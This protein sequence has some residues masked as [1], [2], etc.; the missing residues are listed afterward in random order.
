MLRVLVPLVVLLGAFPVVAAPPAPAKPVVA[1]L[2]FDVP[3]KNEDLAAFRKGLAEM[4]IT[5]LVQGEQLSVVERSR[6]EEV[7]AELELSG[8]GKVDPATAQ[9]IGKLLGARYQVMGSIVPLGKLMSFEVKVVRV[10]TGQVL[11][12]TRERAT[13]DDVFEAEQKLAA[14]LQALVAEAEKLVPPPPPKG[15]TKLRYDTAVK[16]SKALD[17][18]DKKNKD[19]AVKLLNEVVK[20]QPDFKLA[21]LDLLN[22]TK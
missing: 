15:A 8:S 14:T 5:D 22:L 2:Y 12:A 17:A 4:L 3:E 9:K 1:V 10:E 11:K 16:Y 18:K 20:E 6:L 19:A 21:Q 13:V 7:L